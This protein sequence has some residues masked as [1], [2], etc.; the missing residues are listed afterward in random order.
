[1][2]LLNL[3][4][5][6]LNVT[7]LE[8]SIAFYEKLGWKVMF[9]LGRHEA[10]PIDEI[11]RGGSAAR[12]KTVILSLGDDPRRTTKLELMEYVEP[13]ARRAPEAP[14]EET[15]PRRLAL[16]VKDLDG[17]LE[18]LRAAGIEIDRVHEVRSMGGRQRFAL[19]RDP[20]GILLELVELLRD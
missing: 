12:V 10:R 5:V 15:G 14:P 16:R 4:H 11:V 17:T 2:P 1:M 7:D 20:D 9:D 19:F 18:E 13:P 6:N 8:R 3:V